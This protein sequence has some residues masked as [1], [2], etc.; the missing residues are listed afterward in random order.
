MTNDNRQTWEETNRSLGVK[1]KVIPVSEYRRMKKPVSKSG[2]NKIE[3]ILKS[4]KIEYLKERQFAPP[5]K[6]RFDYSFFKWIEGDY[7]KVAIE[8]EGLFSAKSG[9]TT[10]KGYSN[11]CTKYN[12]AAINGWIVLRYT[13]TTVKNLTDDLRAL[14]VIK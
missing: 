8:Y 11:N 6:F 9:H 12:L 1:P 4:Y 5:R 10:I 2:V 7:L 3:A 13:A 14:K